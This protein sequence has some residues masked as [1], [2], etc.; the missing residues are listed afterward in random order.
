MS[1]ADE[2]LEL[3]VTLTFPVPINST[4]G[5]E[6]REMATH[7]RDR[8]VEDPEELLEVVANGISDEYLLQVKPFSEP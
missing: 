3:E 4:L 8:W 2:D 6:P 7:M 1:D 5:Y